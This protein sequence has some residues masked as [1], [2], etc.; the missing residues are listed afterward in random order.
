MR[1][2]LLALKMHLPLVPAVS[3]VN[4]RSKKYNEEKFPGA[5]PTRP[6][7]LFTQGDLMAETVL[8]QILDD[9]RSKR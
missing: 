5:L 8:E 3:S 1:R 9:L 4:C 6:T 2:T 7:E